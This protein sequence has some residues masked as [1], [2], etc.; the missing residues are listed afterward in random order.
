[1]LPERMVAGE[2]TV[3]NHLWPAFGDRWVVNDGD[4]RPFLSYEYD[5]ERGGVW[6]TNHLANSQQFSNYTPACL[7]CAR[8]HLLMLTTR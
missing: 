3:C 7:E 6:V 1:M 4:G 8:G 2:S 5:P